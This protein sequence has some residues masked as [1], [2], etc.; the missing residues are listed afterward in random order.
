MTEQ[1]K[2]SNKILLNMPVKLRSTYTLWSEGH[3]LRSLMSMSTYY[4]HRKDLK[5]FGIN[6]DL[7]PETSNKSNNVIPLIRILEA[8]PAEIPNFAY[9]QNLVHISAC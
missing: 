4:R 9:E 3:D 2:L 1:I 6:I 8:K 7:R 5:K